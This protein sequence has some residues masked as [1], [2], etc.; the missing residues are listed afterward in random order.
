M[1]KRQKYRFVAKGTVFTGK[2]D[3]SALVGNFRGK[4]TEI[5]KDNK[6]SP[7]KIFSKKSF[8]YQRSLENER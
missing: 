2:G 3:Y 8:Y 7:L 6:W 4:G 5:F 1:P